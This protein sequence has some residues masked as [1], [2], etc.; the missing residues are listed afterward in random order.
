MYFDTDVK[1]VNEKFLYTGQKKCSKITFFIKNHPYIFWGVIIGIVVLIIVIIALAFGLSKTSKDEETETEDENEGIFPLSEKSLKEVMNIYDGIGDKDKGTLSQ[2]CEYLKSNASNLKEAQKVYLVYSW[3]TK[4]IVYDHEGLEKDTVIY[5]PDKFF[6]TRKTVCSGY[7][8]LFRRL[9]KEMNYNETKIKNIQGYSKGAG[10]SVYVL[11]KANHEWNA[12]NINGQW[13]SVDTTWD[14][15]KNSSVF[16]YLCTRPECFV[17]DH[18]P[19]N[20]EDQFLP[21]PISLNTFHSLAWTNGK[22]CYY[23][24]EINEDKSYYNFCGKRK[25][26]VKYDL[27]YET[28]LHINQIKDVSFQISNITKGFQVE[29][30]VEKAGKYQLSLFLAD[31]NL[32]PQ[33]IGYIHINCEK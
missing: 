26:T 19:N 32:K 29:L 20:E 2:F 31:E 25:F 3:I 28:Q 24:G 5:D 13:C 7:A 16:Y 17:R 33:H 1:K 11:P 14:A 23:N 9:L 12:V 18:L 30:S 4:N 15:G 10:Y 27:D 8:R 21:S 6:P 22:F